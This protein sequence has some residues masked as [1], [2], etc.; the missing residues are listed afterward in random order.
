MIHSFKAKGIRMSAKKRA[1]NVIIFFTDQQRWDSSSLFGNPL[2]L[3]QNY[4]RF[5]MEGTHCHTAYTCQPVCLPARASL[6][7]GKYAS[8]V[9]CQTN[10]CQLDA[11]ERTLGHIFKENGYHTGYFGKWHLSHDEPVPPEQR[12]GYDEWLASNILE[13]SSD[14]YSTVMYDKEGQP[15]RLPGYRVDAVA[16]A[17]IR[18]IDKNQDKPFFLMMSFIEPHHQN[19]RDEYFAPDGYRERYTGRWTPPDLTALGGTSAYHIGGYWGC[20]KRLDEAFG[21]IL[22]TLRS[23]EL[24]DDTIVLYTADHGCHFRTRNS[25]YKRSCHD[26]CT[27]IP[28]ALSGPGLRGGGRITHPVSLI[29]MPATLLDAAGIE[30]PA[31]MQGA[32]ILP[33]LHGQKDE[34][35]EEVFIQISE[36]ICGRAL[37]TD[38]W[39]YGVGSP[40][41]TK[42]L[43]ASSDTYV[44]Q[45]L[46][47]MDADPYEQSNLIGF[48]ALTELQTQ[49]RERMIKAIKKHEGLDATIIPSEERGCGQMY[50]C[51]PEPLKRR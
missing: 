31:E 47:D 12:S 23:L 25:E 22:D 6:Q 5:A 16:D 15:V 3:T 10:L 13:F 30:V 32:S 43:D 37:R 50:F 14:A 8:N 29:D 18:F 45:F 39:K 1:P 26:G 17:G 28:M 44:E 48:S 42:R 19:H 9:A 36:D 2:E 7:T 33:L 51:A 34:R 21:R 11:S 27:R 24:R 40:D 20:I 41:E 49:L 46:Y 4:D 35:P 38:R